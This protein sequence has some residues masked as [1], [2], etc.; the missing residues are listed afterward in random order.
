M[1]K[2]KILKYK[3]NGKKKIL[4]LMIS[5]SLLLTFFILFTGCTGIPKYTYEEYKKIKAIEGK[6]DTGLSEDNTEISNADLS[7]LEIFYKDI[8]SYN[9]FISDFTNIYNKYYDLL[10]PLFDS[11][12]EEQENIDKKTRYAESIIVCHNDWRD[13]IKEMYVPDF[14]IVYHN[15]FQEYLEKE[16]LFYECIL[17]DNI[18]LTEKY[19]IEASEIYENMEK[20]LKN[21]KN[22]FNA[23]SSE[24]NIEKPFTQ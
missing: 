2:S 9:I 13:E 1:I 19:Q 14:M 21:I 5:A 8:D 24:L 18:E 22:S 4:P 12:D 11:F 17:E 10:L 20:E 23:K 16:I 3:V 15:F 7:E 6:K